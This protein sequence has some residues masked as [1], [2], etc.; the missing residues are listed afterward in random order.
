MGALLPQG[1]GGGERVM[2]QSQ[3]VL[4]LCCFSSAPAP[5]S[6]NLQEPRQMSDDNHLMHMTSMCSTKTPSYSVEIVICPG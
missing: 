6:C 4:V 5:G 3:S 2:S 1:S